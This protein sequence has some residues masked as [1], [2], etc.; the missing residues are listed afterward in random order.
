MVT[1]TESVLFMHG[2]F[3]ED[4][5]NTYWSWLGGYFLLWLLNILKCVAAKA[6]FICC[7]VL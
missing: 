6:N 2:A 7:T 5:T 3:D 4:E 1:V